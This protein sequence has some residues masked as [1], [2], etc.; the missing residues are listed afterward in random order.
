MRKFYLFFVLITT[1]IMS[2][3]GTQKH[4]DQ[5]EVL[6][7]ASEA[8][9][10]LESYSF[11]M[12]INMNVM[13]MMETTMEGTGDVTHNPD[14]MFMTMSMGM[15]GMSMNFET[16]VHEE[17][18]FMSMFG[19]WFTIDKEEMG[20]DS[21]DQL[22]KEEMEKLIRLED[23]FVMTEEDDQYI[24]TLSGEG[25]EF[26]EIVKPYIESSSGNLPEDPALGEVQDI[27]VNNL[28][29]EIGINKES[30]IMTSQ[31]VQADLVVD[32]E[33]MQLDGTIN[34]SAVNEVDPVEI[35]DEVR[36]TATEDFMG[37]A[38]GLEEPMTFE[39]I[40]ETVDFTIPQVTALPEGY[41][42]V[43]SWYE[44]ESEMIMLNYEKD[45]ENGFAFS[46]YPSAE[47]YGEVPEDETTERVTINENEGILS[48]MD[49]F[50]ILTWEQDGRFLELMGGGPELTSENFIEF[51][52]SVQ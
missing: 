40:Q 4:M 24:L 8:V 11:D 5:T 17:E 18:A 16:Y 45:L 47:A 52:E 32:G 36:E 35:P 23:Q 25:D 3:C 49:G 44:E 10:K 7:Q 39:E 50:I 22:N 27:S 2:A 33:A 9:E 30:M 12:L 1:F 51:A 26:S 46:I 19:E 6:Q 42:M 34:I 15:P 29:L 13:D 31:S 14:T 21:F 48:D 37:G 38:F 28:D 43:D 41:S 20:L